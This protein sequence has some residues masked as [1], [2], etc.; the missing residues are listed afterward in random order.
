MD[1]SAVNY[2]IFKLITWKL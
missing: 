2:A 1:S